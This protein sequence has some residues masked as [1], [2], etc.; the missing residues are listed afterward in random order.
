MLRSLSF[1]FAL[2]L[3]T[4][5]AQAAAPR[6]LAGQYDGGEPEIAAGL[7][8]SPEGRFRYGMS[9]GAL[10]ERAEGRWE[11]DS[12]KIFL[13]S[14]P[15]TPPR[16]DLVSQTPAAAGE[17]RVALSV[18]DA[19]SVQYFNAVAVLSDGRTIG[20]QLGYEDWVIS[21]KPGETVVS[22]KF[23]LPV[24][25]LESERFALSAGSASAA[26]FRFSPNDLGTATFAQEPLTV[27]TGGVLVLARHD[28]KIHFRPKSGGC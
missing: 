25:D 2:V 22:V 18:P 15:V 17:F 21:L 3:G 12:N 7:Q 20:S 4:S 6:C 16:F 14:D 24:F 11:G 13:T 9:Y 8:L 26:R 27:E 23:L 1:F 28:R 10:D 5:A 19:I